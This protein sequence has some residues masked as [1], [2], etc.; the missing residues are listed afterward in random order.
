MPNVS[1]GFKRIAHR[2]A[3]G[4]APENTLPAI[5]LAFE[6]YHVD[7]V[8]IDLRPSKDGVPVVIHDTTLERTTNGQG[9]VSNHT[10]EDLK[11]LSAG[12]G[13]TIPTLQEVL[14]EFPEA[15]FFLEIKEK[16]PA[17][18]DK[19]LKVVEHIHGKG[20]LTIGSFHRP[21]MRRLRELKPPSIHSTFSRD[22]VFWT[23]LKFHLGIHRLHSPSRHASLPRQEYGLRLDDPDWIQ[24][25]HRHEIRVYYWTI[26]DPKEMAML[27]E[28]GADGIMTNYPERLNEVV[29]V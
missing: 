5:R 9:L 26:D 28:R 8:E 17:F 7:M 23:Y 11:K 13:A 1:S 10:V 3:S 20:P 25:L 19:V 21:V 29:G 15:G 16:D 24:F 2:G 12:E 14:T 22:E 6:K 18:V 4:E 27:I